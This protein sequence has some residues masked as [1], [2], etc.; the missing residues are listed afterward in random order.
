[1]NCFI[2]CVSNF[3]VQSSDVHSLLFPMQAVSSSPRAVLN[4][5]MAEE[6]FISVCCFRIWAF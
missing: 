3:V 1:M 2:L 5:V 4:K 6:K